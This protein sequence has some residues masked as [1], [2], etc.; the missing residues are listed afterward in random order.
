VVWVCAGRKS[1]A[2]TPR[3]LSLSVRGTQ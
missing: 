1:N 3:R 2:D